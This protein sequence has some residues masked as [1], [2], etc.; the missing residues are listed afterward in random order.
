MLP[1]C[2]PKLR[3]LVLFLTYTGARISEALRVNWEDDVSLDRQTVTLRRTK[4]GK[5]RTVHLPAPL[6][7]E[8]TAVP[9]DDRRGK[10]FD[11]S[12][13]KA[14]YGP[15]KRACKRAGVNYLPPHQQGRHTYA[16]WLRKYAGLDLIG[17]KEAG[18]WDTLSMVSRYAH[19]V[20]A[21]SA[22]AADQMPDVR[23]LVHDGEGDDGAKPLAKENDT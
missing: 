6:L 4:N 18:G 5:P 17:L 1:H 22:K 13:R 9:Q 20:P 10:L 21:E 12:A 23:S 7:D 8:L 15:L 2:T 16:T 3:R 11:W 19:V 14:V